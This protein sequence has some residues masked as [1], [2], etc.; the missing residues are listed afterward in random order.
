M[1]D[2]GVLARGTP[3]QTALQDWSLGLLRFR[4]CWQGGSSARVPGTRAPELMLAV[5]MLG[6]AGNG[7]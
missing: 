7:G 3:D 2:P 6:W 5:E 1:G 4:G